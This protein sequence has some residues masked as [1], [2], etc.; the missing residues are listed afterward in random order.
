VP[1]LLTAEKSAAMSGIHRIEFA[2]V[3]VAVFKDRAMGACV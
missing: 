1:R 2:E 3:R